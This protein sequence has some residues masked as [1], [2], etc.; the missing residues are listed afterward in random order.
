MLECKLKKGELRENWNSP[1]V[2][3]P[4]LE[5][6]VKSGIDTYVHHCLCHKPSHAVNALFVPSQMHHLPK[7]HHII[8]ISPA[9]HSPLLTTSPLL[10]C[11]NCIAYHNVILFLPNMH[12]FSFHECFIYHLYIFHIGATTHIQTTTI[13]E[14]LHLWLIFFL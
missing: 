3:L 5:G 8:N 13:V 14:V 1:V 4:M 12:Y 2:V 6:P 9:T 10:V 7:M 11:H